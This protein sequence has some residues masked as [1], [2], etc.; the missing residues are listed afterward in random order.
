[1]G[2]G[3]AWSEEDLLYLESSWGK[4]KIS[5]IAKKLGRTET[6]VKAKAFKLGLSSMLDNKDFLIAK[7][8]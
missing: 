3:K 8:L 1:M 5:T 6:A 2:A 7:G 4:T